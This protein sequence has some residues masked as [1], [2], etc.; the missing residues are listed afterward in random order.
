MCDTQ[1]DKDKQTEDVT[2]LVHI[3][4]YTIAKRDSDFLKQFEPVK[5]K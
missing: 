1:E 5:E 3:G 4:Q 2:E